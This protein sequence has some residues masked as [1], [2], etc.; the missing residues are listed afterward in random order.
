M[1]GGQYFAWGKGFEAGFV[2]FLIAVLF[3]SFG[4]ICLCLCIAEMTSILPF[5]GAISDISII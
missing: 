2:G 4:Y 3:V 5:S 1:V